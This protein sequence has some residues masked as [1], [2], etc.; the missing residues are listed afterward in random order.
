MLLKNVYVLYFDPVF[1]IRNNADAIFK[2]KE[3]IVLG[4]MR[5]PFLK[6]NQNFQIRNNNHVRDRNQSVS[7]MSQTGEYSS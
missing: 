5:I 2:M 3:L 6:T 4:I 1:R 7:K